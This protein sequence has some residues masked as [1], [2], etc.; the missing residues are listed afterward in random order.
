[1]KINKKAA[2]AIENGDSSYE[3]YGYEIIEEGDWVADHKMQY[4]EIIFKDKHSGK[5]YTLWSSRSGS[6]F[7]DYYYESDDWSVEVDVQEVEKKEKIT[8][9]WV[10]VK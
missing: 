7:S 9:E 10:A 8:H 6:P 5:F 3:D 4:K 2:L 1:M